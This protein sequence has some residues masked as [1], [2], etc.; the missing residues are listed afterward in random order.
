MIRRHPDSTRTDTLFPY[1]TLFRSASIA[2]PT[3]LGD[4]SRQFGRFQS[5]L[6]LPEIDQPLAAI[7]REI[8]HP[9]ACGGVVCL[10]D[11]AVEDVAGRVVTAQRIER[12]DFGVERPAHILRQAGKIGREHV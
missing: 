6:I 10:S 2:V 1:T 12:I 4:A 7:D 9:R 11:D 3:L 8:D 5:P